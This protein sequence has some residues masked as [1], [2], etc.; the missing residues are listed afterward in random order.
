MLTASSSGVAS[1]KF[2]WGKNWVGPK[3]LILGEQQYCVGDTAS[4][5]TT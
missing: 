2:F 5:S 1:I 3:Y 4:Q